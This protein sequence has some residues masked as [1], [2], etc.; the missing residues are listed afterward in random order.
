MI[1]ARAL[2]LGGDSDAEAFFAAWGR[3][4]LKT[5]GAP[6]RFAGLF[7]PADLSAIALGDVVEGKRP[8]LS[9]RAAYRDGKG[10][11]RTFYAP[12]EMAKALHEAGMTLVWDDV[13]RAHPRLAELAGSLA[14]L[15]AARTPI[16]IQ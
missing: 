6:D 4:W 14:K 3:K 16:V 9:Y 1:D 15:V 8:S 7:S 13:Q 5:S 10:S 12:L 11:G 2:L